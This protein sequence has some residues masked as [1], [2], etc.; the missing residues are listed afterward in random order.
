MEYNLS[1][2]LEIEK[3]QAFLDSLGD[4]TGIASAIYDFEGQVSIRS[5]WQ[6]LCLEFHR[7][8]PVTRKYCL[9]SDAIL[10]QKIVTDEKYY[11]YQCKNGLTDA[12]APIIL[13]G[14][15]VFN[16]FIGQFFTEEPDLDYFQK[17]AEIYG[18]ETESYLAAVKSTPVIS[19]QKLESILGFLDHYTEMLTEMILHRINE[20]RVSGDLRKSEERFKRLTENARDMIYRM[21]LPDGRYEYISPASIS[22]T[23]YSPEDF[24]NSPV[25]IQQIIHPDWQQ[26]FEEQWGLLLRGEMPPTYEYQI[27]QKSGEPRWL[28]QRNV[29]IK[30]PDGLPVAMEGIV[31]DITQRKK[32]EDSLRQSE[33]KYRLLV[34]NQTD[35]VVKVDPNGRFLFVSPSYCEM[36]GISEAEL[37]GKAFMPLVHEDDRESTAKAM[38]NLYKPPHKAYMEQRAMTKNGWRWLSWM[39]TSVFDDK[40]QVV[41]IIGVGRDITEQKEIEERQ[42][43]LEQQLRQ[44]QKMEAVGKLAG[45]VAHDFNNILAAIM[46]YSELALETAGR[47]EKCKG[48]ISNVIKAAERARNLV[49]QILTFSRKVQV[50]L[51]PVNMNKEIRRTIDILGRTLPKMISVEANFSADLKLVNADPT[52]MEQ[53]LINLASNAADA[54]PDGGRLLFETGNV[55]LDDEYCS[56]HAEVEP[57][58]YVLL[59]VSDTGSG[60][61]KDTIE[62]IFEPFFT[63]KDIGKG[64]GLG[65]S[66]VFGIVKGHRGHIYCYS[67]SGM[68][69]AFKIY[70]PAV[71]SNNALAYPDEIEQQ[72]APGGNE[73][74]LLVDDEES[75][76]ELGSAALESAGYKVITAESGE[77]AH[78]IYREQGR[79]LDLIILD[80]G[81]P[82]MGGQKC[83]E[84]ILEL[85]PRAKIIIASGYSANGQARSALDSGALD[86]V[87][88]PFRRSSLLT[89][90]R[91]AL[92]RD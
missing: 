74:I 88:K 34:E 53:V 70:L 24:K 85:N 62:K 61:E 45:G 57:G 52:Q 28:F 83:L 78:E 51:R 68:G 26:Y 19:P 58:E 12:V 17:Q 1:E 10:T 86:Y 63:T 60:I 9:E 2:L 32:A 44:S 89:A 33:E 47:E 66:S 49:E 50:Q 13:E 69:A 36:F 76:R 46:G 67:E 18:F 38:E 82:G 4:L 75:L 73:A 84:L 16:M 71:K 22:I 40:G 21:S 5:R 64:T 77:A 59:E 41:E 56:V 31:T 81:M 14:E 43:L 90:V 87:A 11:I 48:Y 54:M 72:Q 7:T 3:I 27:I 29:L 42:R 35:M 39:D 15:H 65:L 55:F 8:N 30:G 79:Q 25:L 37:L 20:L 91:N 92:D 80:L 23:G 6:R